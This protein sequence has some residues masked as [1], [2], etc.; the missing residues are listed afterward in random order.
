ME[1]A[2]G[3]APGGHDGRSHAI[4]FGDLGISDVI[5]SGLEAAGI[6]TTFPIQA[7]ALP[8]ALRGQ[9]IIG[10]ART[11]TGKTLAFGIPVLQRLTRGG[12]RP[13]ALIVVPTRELAIQV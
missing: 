12:T 2:P 10:Q 7:L 9:D 5:C 3:A 4:A 11:G 1:H 13:Q 8:L 6:T